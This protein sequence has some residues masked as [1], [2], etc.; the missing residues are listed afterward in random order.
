MNVEQIPWALHFVKASLGV[1]AFCIQL[2]KP[3]SVFP[4]GWGTASFLL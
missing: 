1:V 2:L 4:A 3:G